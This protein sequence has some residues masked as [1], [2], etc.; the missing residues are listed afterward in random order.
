MNYALNTPVKR[1]VWV[2]PKDTPTPVAP[3]TGQETQDHHRMTWLHHKPQSHAIFP[4]S[5]LSGRKK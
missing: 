2:P 4:I 3:H 1:P 5:P